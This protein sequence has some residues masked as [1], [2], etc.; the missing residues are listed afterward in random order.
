MRRQNEKTKK[1][2]IL[3]VSILL[4]NY[5]SSYA[6]EI[7]P[8]SVRCQPFT[9]Y[10]EKDIIKSRTQQF[11]HIVYNS[12]IP[13]VVTYKVKLTSTLSLKAGASGDVNAL[14]A[15]TSINFEMG[16]IGS[17]ETETT[18]TWKVPAGSKYKLTAGKELA[19]VKGEISK[20]DAY[21]SITN[22]NINVKG[23]YRTYQKAVRVK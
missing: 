17:R 5:S 19:D 4:L 15:K 18:I 2:L 23:S 12:P 20:V 21:C 11:S 9:T 10:T 16:Y 3:S 7:K 1:I 22:R 13:S 8:T 6:N 14:L